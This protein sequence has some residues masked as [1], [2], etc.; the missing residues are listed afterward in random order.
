MAAEPTSIQEIAEIQ[1][2]EQVFHA[3]KEAFAA[4]PMPDLAQRRDDLD[5]L[6]GALV[7]FRKRL[8]DAVSTDFGN[9]SR[10]ESMMEIMTTIQGMR[11][12]RRH[13]R[14]WMKPSRRRAGLLMATTSCKVY[15]QPKGIVGVIVPW[16]YPLALAIGPLTCA[17]AAGNRV[18]LKM[19]EST[20]RTGEVLCEMIQSI[21]DDSHVA[22]ILGEVETGKAF[23]RLPLD[24]LVF[25]GSTD[26]GRH[27]MHAA[28]DNLTP[29]TLEL[30]GKSP[31]IISDDVPMDMAAERICF[32]K[33]LSLGFLGEGEDNLGVV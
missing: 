23:S 25:T 16:N 20:P 13:L 21:F 33:A 8:A 3:Q 28:S 14:R 17:L 29:V 31:T 27:I 24:H 30:G 18:M 11:Y 12:A 22:I 15:Y 19:S 5:R 6:R 32:G 26:V 7:T 4:N 9:R 2:M 10:H 1:R